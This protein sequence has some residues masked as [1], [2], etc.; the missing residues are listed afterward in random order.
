MSTTRLQDWPLR[1]DAFV[2]QR[3]CMPFA[4]G[5]QDCCQFARH[6]VAAL[7]GSDPAADW[8]LRPYRTAKGAAGQ[9]ARLGGIAALPGRAGLSEIPLLRAGRG[10][11]ALV[12]NAGRPALGIVLG[13][14]VAYVGE[15]GLAFVPVTACTNTW[16]VG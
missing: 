5:S 12:P 4:W 11:L 16:R 13:A 15:Q 8:G 10:D 1:L 3:R 7:T 9:L 6:A 2:E 14:K